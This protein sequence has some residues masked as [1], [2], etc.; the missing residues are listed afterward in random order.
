M[1]NTN[2]RYVRATT[3]GPPS[4]LNVTN[5]LNVGSGTDKLRSLSC[6]F[7]DDNNSPSG[8][9]KF[10]PSSATTNSS[11]NAFSR[12]RLSEAL[13]EYDENGVALNGDTSSNANNVSEV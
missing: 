4:M 6:E 2:S 11:L 13:D 8:S 10:Y 12:T 5:L 3:A 9:N 1:A 7:I